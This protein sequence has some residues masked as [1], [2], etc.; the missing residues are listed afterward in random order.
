VRIVLFVVVTGGAILVM[1]GAGAGTHEPFAFFSGTSSWPSQL[2]RALAVLLF[3]WFIDFTWRGTAETTRR[4]GARY[5][6]VGT[7]P[8]TRIGSLVAYFRRNPKRASGFVWRRLQKGLMDATLW[9][10]RPHVSVR[11]GRA[12]ALRLHDGPRPAG[13]ADDGGIDGTRI[14]RR[15]IRL[16]H[17]GPRLLRTLLWLAAAFCFALLEQ[18]IF[19]GEAPDVPARGVGDR[20]LFQTTTIL[21]VV[22]TIVLMVLVSDAT[23]LTWRFIRILRDRRTIYP[24]ETVRRFAAQLGPELVTHAARPIAARIHDR[25]VGNR[26][27]RNS[28][29]DPWI[30]AQLLAD[31]TDAIARLIFFPLILLG[32]LFLAR[33]PLFDNWSPDN[34]VIVILVTYLLWTIAMATMLNVSAESARRTALEAMRRDLLWLQG[35]GEKYRPLAD[36]FPSLIRQVEELRKGAFAPFFEQPLVRAVLVPLGGAGGF[37]LLELLAF[38]RP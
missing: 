26:L 32:L 19:G 9:M 29:L 31:H 15:Y 30:D 12:A 36:R 21:A 25:N 33:S 27:Q 22:A 23:I 4:V 24:Q 14:W 8:K 13:P 38:T 2:L 28:I 10:W 16:L 1:P 34:V 20:A 18:Q 5:F 6:A 37:Q 11:G 7:V 3:G 35:S 17:G